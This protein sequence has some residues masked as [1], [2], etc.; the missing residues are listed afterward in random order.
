MREVLVKTEE[1]NDSPA[2][3]IPKDWDCLTI[4]DCLQKGLILDVQ[5]GNHGEDHPKSEDFVTEGI[6]FVMA[7]DLVNGQINI[8]DCNKIS[9]K[10]YKSLRVG[11][12]RPADVLLSHK[13]TIGL[14]AIVPDWLQDVMLTPQVTYYRVAEGKQLLNRFLFCFFQSHLFQRKLQILSA[15]STRSYIGITLQKTLSILIPSFDEQKKIAE[16]MDT[17]DDAIARTSSL[18][19]KLKQI[20]AGLLHDL[21]TR[22]LDENG[23]LRDPEAHP[24]EFKDS[25]LG[26]IPRDW[27]I[28]TIGDLVESA[29][30]GP[31][32][33]NLKTE[34]YVNQPEVRVVRLQNI[35]NGYFDD[36]DKAYVSY[37]H[38]SKLHRHEVVAGDLIVACLGDENHPIARACLYPADAKPG[39]VKADCF[40]LRLHPSMAIHAY[41]MYVLNCSSTRG[42]INLLGQGVT[43]DRVNLTTLLKVRVRIP[44]VREQNHIVA[45][46]DSH[47]TRIRKEETYLNKLKLQKQGLMHDL[48]TGKV[49][50][51]NTKN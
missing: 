26:Q 12:A 38:A 18:I 19:T 51:K 34:H 29:I 7:K 33:S 25:A 46:I 15:Q 22:G 27:H 13:G 49:R 43:R 8:A 35:E 36:S 48:L 20:K 17:V 37:N 9:W 28:H 6:P 23:Q 21:L 16:I 39:I 14:T 40:R 31:F 24:E 32:G 50:V 10:Q 11:F 45:I 1:F 2:G 42:D 3:R 47:D 30:D 41:V 5:D 4:N 44:P